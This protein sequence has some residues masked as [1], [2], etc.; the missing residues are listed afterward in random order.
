MADHEVDTVRY[1]PAAGRSAACRWR[2]AA[3]EVSSSTSRRSPASTAGCPATSSMPV[4]RAVLIPS[5]WVLPGKWRAREFVSAASALVSSRR[6]SGTTAWARTRS[7]NSADA[8]FL[9]AGSAGRRHRRRRPVDVLP[10]GGLC[11]RRR[12]QRQR[13]PRNLRARR[14]IGPPHRGSSAGRTIEPT[15]RGG[16]DS[17]ATDAARASGGPSSPRFVANAG[18]HHLALDRRSTAVA[19]W[20]RKACRWRHWMICRRARVSNPGHVVNNDRYLLLAKVCGSTT[21]RHM[22]LRACR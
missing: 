7:R 19:S 1:S 22:C 15:S 3:P 9:S 16:H 2:E 10:R 20:H 5:R 14:L 18:L 17:C 11:H 4:P 6:K 8:R 13:R 12:S 21:R